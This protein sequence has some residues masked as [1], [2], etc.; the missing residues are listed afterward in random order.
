MLVVYYFL[1]PKEVDFAKAAKNSLLYLSIRN[2]NL[3]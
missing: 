1:I 2:S 3:L